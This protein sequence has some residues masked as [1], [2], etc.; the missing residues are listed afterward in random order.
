MLNYRLGVAVAV[1]TLL[2]GVSSTA[3]AQGGMSGMAGMA[4]MSGMDHMNMGPEI[5][6]PAGAIYTKADV[7]FMQGMIAHHAQAVVMSRL[8]DSHGANA[9]VLKLSKKIDQSQ[10]PEIQIMQKWL[11][12]NN[13]FAPDTASWHHVRMEGML[14]DE[15]LTQLENSKGVDFDRAYLTFMIMHHAGA[16]K[17]VDDLFMS[18][19]AGQEVDVS[20][21][22]ND[23]VTAQTSEIGIMR[24]LMAKL[25]PK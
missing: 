1:C 7:E 19:R 14:T 24:G 25:P 4:G 12:R 8:A 9:Q 2:A 17:M 20:V 3:S 22:A 18:P 13:Q 11:E 15:Q 21:F 10:I 6:I 5:V 16:L 23:V